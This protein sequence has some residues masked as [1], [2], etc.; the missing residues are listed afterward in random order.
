MQQLANGLGKGALEQSGASRLQ[1]NL[2]RLV[3]IRASWVAMRFKDAGCEWSVRLRATD[4]EIQ[5][6]TLNM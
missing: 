3:A 4:G 1:G 6:R 2:H 5:N